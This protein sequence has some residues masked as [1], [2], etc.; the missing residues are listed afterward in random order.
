MRRTLALRCTLA[1]RRTLALHR[2]LRHFFAQHIVATFRLLSHVECA[3]RAA[4]CWPPPIAALIRCMAD[5]SAR[6]ADKTARAADAVPLESFGGGKNSSRATEPSLKSLLAL[7]V[8][9]LLVVS[10]TFTDSVLSKFGPQAVQGRNP[11]PW[12]EVLRGVFVVVLYAVTINLSR[13]NI[14]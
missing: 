4:F 11:T 9:F 14:L 12:G 7:L 13:R 8:I 1:L 2:G 3:V 6:V 5:K 10:D